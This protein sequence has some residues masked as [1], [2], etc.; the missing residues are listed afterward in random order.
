MGTL[1][2]L[3]EDSH[4][5]SEGPSSGLPIPLG[6]QDIAQ[7]MLPAD[8]ERALHLLQQMGPATGSLASIPLQ[9]P[10]HSTTRAATLTTQSSED[11]LAA[12][13]TATAVREQQVAEFTTVAGIQAHAVAIGASATEEEAAQAAQA[14]AI[15]ALTAAKAAMAGEDATPPTACDDVGHYFHLKTARRSFFT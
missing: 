7:Y 14:A 13:A 15:A 8:Q 2:D 11:T 12:A 5:I 9:L 4:A 10:Y 3:I 6:L 1:P